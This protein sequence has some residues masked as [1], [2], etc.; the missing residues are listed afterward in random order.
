[1]PVLRRLGAA[2]CCFWFAQRSTL[3]LDL[4]R[5]QLGLF[6]LGILLLSV[7]NW[8][9]FYGPDGLA[10]HHPDSLSWLALLSHPWQHWL[11]LALALVTGIGFT[12]GLASRVSAVLFFLSISGL[13]HRNYDLTNGQDL[14][15]YQL[16][17]FCCFAPLGRHLSLDR[18]LRRDPS[19]PPPAEIWTLRLMQLGVMANYLFSGPGKW[20]DSP[21]WRDG[22][23]LYW[24]VLSERWF[25]FPDP[26]L[27]TL[28]GVSW[29]LTFF[30]LAVEHLVPI[31]IFIPRFTVVCLAA[32][33]ML[34][35]P[36]LVLMSPGV[37][38][39]QVIM[40]I[41]FTLFWPQS[42]LERLKARLTHWG[43]LLLLV[44][45][46][47]G[48]APAAEPH[49]A[50]FYSHP[51]GGSSGHEISQ[52]RVR[53]IKPLLRN[54]G[55]TVWL[56]GMSTTA[57]PP[58]MMGEVGQS[59]LWLGD[60]ERHQQLFGVVLPESKLMTCASPDRPFRLPAGYGIPFRDHEHFMLVDSRK[61]GST[62]EL[63]IHT[64]L[65]LSSD[66]T[67]RPVHP[68]ALHCYVGS[69]DRPP[70]RASLAAQPITVSGFTRPAAGDLAS[71]AL[72]NPVT[73]RWQHDGLAG[74]AETDVTLLL[75]PLLPARL[76][77][78]YPV[79]EG[80][81][82]ALS[83]VAEDGNLVEVAGPE[84]SRSGTPGSPILLPRGPRYLL[85]ARLKG[86]AGTTLPTRAELL[87]LLAAQ[88]RQL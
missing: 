31:L 72:G 36:M 41:G 63:V 83:L 8:D 71:D 9:R 28:M 13:F 70:P 27:L 67:L 4:F 20:I 60:P 6:W 84:L 75:A 53:R 77:A 81:V 78:F 10:P 37:H 64:T 65:E 33:Y 82:E 35:L 30:T 14:L 56:T 3:L 62:A 32:C 11:A 48:C 45:L 39:Y 86:G 52:G 15:A 43:I 40:L 23:A 87:L 73:R 7:P 22:S 19:P 76:V 1:M 44:V 54:R 46:L 61:S 12:L 25:R 85:R 29:V 66:P 55:E 69:A 47:P 74:T 2:W 21:T 50:T 18:W 34:H 80:P 17:F 42:W 51:F 79:V 57:A 5:I 38:F 68:A 58:E 88:E 16:L 26:P 24:V 59:W 49:R